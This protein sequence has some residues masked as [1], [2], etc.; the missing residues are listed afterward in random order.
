MTKK[1]KNREYTKENKIPPS[2]YVISL[3]PLFLVLVL[4]WCYIGFYT[5]NKQL[6]LNLVRLSKLSHGK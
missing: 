5:L 1:L 6:Y 3:L 2:R 4:N